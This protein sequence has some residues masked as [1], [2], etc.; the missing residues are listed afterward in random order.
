MGTSVQDVSDKAAIGFRQMHQA[1]DVTLLEARNIGRHVARISNA[2]EKLPRTFKV[3]VRKAVSQAIAELHPVV[4][5]DVQSDLKILQ[6][7]DYNT[8]NLQEESCKE[9]FDQTVESISIDSDKSHIAV[10]DCRA[11]YEGKT[12]KKYPGLI[13]RPDLR[14]FSHRAPFVWFGQLLICEVSITARHV[15]SSRWQSNT[16][17]EENMTMVEIYIK[18]K[19][20]LWNRQLHARLI[21]NRTHGLSSPTNISL[22]MPRRVSADDSVIKCIKAGD[23]EGFKS[24]IC[25]GRV[26]PT[27]VVVFSEQLSDSSSMDMDLIGVSVKSPQSSG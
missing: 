5:Q 10:E 20:P 8:E 7:I 18:P 2:Q 22:V 15:R 4:R 13:Q 23:I 14:R 12:S 11:S 21:F 27:D 9:A 6:T 3:I 17:R 26:W 25:Q 24:G 1:A 16:H 19:L